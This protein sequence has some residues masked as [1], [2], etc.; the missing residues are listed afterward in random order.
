MKNEKD[1]KYCCP[2][3]NT[4]F[5]L[6][7]MLLALQDKGLSISDISDICSIHEKVL[8]QRTKMFFMHIPL[9]TIEEVIWVYIARQH[10]FSTK[11]RLFTVLRKVLRL[12]FY[13]ILEVLQLPKKYYAEVRKQCIGLFQ[14]NMD[15]NK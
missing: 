7:E 6:K 14:E 1:E 3:C 15:T 11:L 5:A 2:N 10:G 4:V 8:I 13:E 12:D 9:D